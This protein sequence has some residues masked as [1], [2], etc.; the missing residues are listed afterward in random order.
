MDNQFLFLYLRLKCGF[1]I[2]HN[3]SYKDKTISI[4]AILSLAS[5]LS[6]SPLTGKCIS[7]SWVCDGDYDCEDLSDE[8]SCEKSPCKPPRYPCAND[9]SVCLPPESICNGRYDCSD[10]SDE[11]HFC[12][13]TFVQITSNQFSW[14]Y[15]SHLSQF[16]RSPLQLIIKYRS[17]FFT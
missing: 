16:S 14:S 2:I 13:M 5:S 8:E 1:V 15:F 6:V 9:T 7:K 3:I 12:G 11:G 4:F 10:H 17:I